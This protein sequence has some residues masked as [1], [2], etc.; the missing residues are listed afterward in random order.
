MKAIA[1]ILFVGAVFVG[2][3]SLTHTWVREDHEKFSVHMGLLTSHECYDDKCEWST[4]LRYLE[5]AQG[6]HL[7]GALL[8]VVTALAG[9]V[10]AIL[11]ILCGVAMLQRRPKRVLSV[12]LASLS[13]VT[14]LTAIAFIVIEKFSPAHWAFGVPVFFL[15]VIACLIA[16]ILALSRALTQSSGQPMRPMMA[17]PPC[18]TCHNPLQFV[19]AYQRWFCPA[20]NR[21]L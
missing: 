6:L 3:G 21:Y 15:G 9:V 4:F 5:H 8:S 20:C 13:A 17:A 2:V 11:S 19:P 14:L 1:I 16:G 10:V 18:M 7:V 12:V